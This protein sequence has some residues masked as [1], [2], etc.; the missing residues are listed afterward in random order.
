MTRF[1]N[2][3]L[4]LASLLWVGAKGDTGT[5]TPGLPIGQELHSQ[6]VLQ[7]K[8]QVGWV[9]KEWLAEL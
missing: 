2:K 6:D 9:G 4:T 1:G 3:Q 7:P 5:D 8:G